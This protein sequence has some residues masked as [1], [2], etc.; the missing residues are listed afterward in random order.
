MNTDAPGTQATEAIAKLGASSIEAEESLERLSAA[1]DIRGRHK[2]LTAK[3]NKL[4][5]LQAKE[6][7]KKLT[8]ERGT[9]PG[10][11]DFYKLAMHIAQNLPET[12]Q[13]TEEEEASK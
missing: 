4:R 8:K 10:A 5:K 11:R 9:L 1:F 12:A 3:V 7:A 6:A 13:N 2:R